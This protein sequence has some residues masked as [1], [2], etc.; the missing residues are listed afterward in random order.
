VNSWKTETL[1]ATP[2]PDP[3]PLCRAVTRM[4]SPKSKITRTTNHVLL[5]LAGTD[6]RASIAQL[7]ATTAAID[8]H[9]RI[10]IDAWICQP[11]ADPPTDAPD[12]ARWCGDPKAELHK[13]FEADTANV[14]LIRRDGYIG[15]FH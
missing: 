12:A 5:L 6:E 4:R 11:G 1:T 14:V 13:R 8:A 15:L 2:L 10:L 7:A 3:R 9:T